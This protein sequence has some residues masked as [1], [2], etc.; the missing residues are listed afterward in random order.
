M[1]LTVLL[2]DLVIISSVGCFYL[3]TESIVTQLPLKFLRIPVP[4][5]GK[6][7]I[8]FRVSNMRLLADN[9]DE[10]AQRILELDD[11]ELIDTFQRAHNT[12]MEILESSVTHSRKR[13]SRNRFE[14][15]TGSTT[16]S[17]NTTPTR[18]RT[19]QPQP[20]SPSSREQTK[21]KKPLKRAN[22]S[23]KRT[24][25]ADPDSISPRKQTKSLTKASLPKPSS[26]ALSTGNVS[27][28]ERNYIPSPSDM[29]R[30]QSCDVIESPRGTNLRVTSSDSAHDSAHDSATLESPH[31][32]DGSSQLSDFEE[33]GPLLVATPVDSPSVRRTKPE[34][35]EAEK[36]AA[37]LE[38]D[39]VGDQRFNQLFLTLDSSQ[40]EESSGNERPAKV[41]FLSGGSATSI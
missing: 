12:Y 30:S 41:G 24:S 8:P 27:S 17:G 14:R 21:E 29:S 5:G 2:D 9:L 16:S 11:R 18:P 6:R 25:S 26:L 4:A 33:S 23:I 13:V 31:S 39:M 37:T 32:G 35:T 34:I 22:S 38:L 15:S 7:T 28:A 10:L 36:A 20:D 40:K 1:Q 19:R 3:A